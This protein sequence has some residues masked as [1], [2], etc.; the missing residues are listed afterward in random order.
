MAEKQGDR[1]SLIQSLIAYLETL[2]RDGHFFVDGETYDL[3]DTVQLT[4][5]PIGSYD[6]AGLQMILQGEQEGFRKPQ[7]AVIMGSKSDRPLADKVTTTLQRLGI[8]FETVI[9]SAHRTP[10]ALVAYIRS[11]ERRGIRIIIAIAGLAAHLPGV[12]AAH[13][14]LPVIGV[15]VAS[16]SLQGIDALLSITQMP[17]GV[18]VSSVGIDA[19][20]NAALLA[21][22]MLQH[23]NPSIQKALAHYRESQKSSVLGLTPWVE[24]ATGDALRETNLD[25]LPLVKRGKVRDIY[26]LGDRLLIVAT[27]RISVFDVVLPTPIPGKGRIL[28]AISAFWFWKFNDLVP[29][30]LISTRYTDLPG[31]LPERFPY[32][33]GRIM[34]VRKLQ[35]FPIEC[36]VR[37]YLAGSGWAQ[38]RETGRIQD[39]ELPSGL[40]ES[41]KL[42]EPIFTPT[43][44]AAEG[45]DQPL[46]FAEMIKQIGEENAHK[47]K[48]RSL[49][50]YKKAAAY[51]ESRGIIIADT[52]FEFGYDDEGNIF[53]IDEIL[54]PDS[55]RFWPLESYQPGKPQP[56]FDKQYVRDY[57]SSL[58]WNKQPPGPPLPPEVV[59]KTVEKYHEAYRRLVPV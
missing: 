38:Y 23:E 9:L 43:T 7:V 51:A 5:R 41:D 1:S 17:P 12:I 44:K 52:K 15:P 20:T 47:L 19:G 28:T 13:T 45:H 3:G 49:T 24:P 39:V 22:R 37:G 6:G 34:I 14:L 55:S 10:E 16:G 54:T 25:R 4:V 36:I 26:D 40:R 11:A 50:L 56:S 58:G 32:L 59:Q 46:T 33:N 2:E 8:G 31:D 18:P 30:H 48:E 29:N 21:A 42:P 53:L 27:D 57:T 35:V